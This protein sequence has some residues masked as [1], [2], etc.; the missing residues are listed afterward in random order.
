MNKFEEKLNELLVKKIYDLTNRIEDPYISSGIRSD[1]TIKREL[2]DKI[3]AA[4]TDN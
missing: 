1:L 3:L 4:L 2:L